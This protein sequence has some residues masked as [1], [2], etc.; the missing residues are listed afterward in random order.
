LTFINCRFEESIEFDFPQI[1]HLIFQKS[2]RMQS[3][4]NFNTAKINRL[5]INKTH[6]DKFDFDQPDLNRLSFTSSTFDTFSISRNKNQLRFNF[7][8]CT[9]AGGILFSE[10]NF[11][12]KN[13]LRG[14]SVNGN[15]KFKEC[16]NDSIIRILRSDLDR[17]KKTKIKGNFIFSVMKNGTFGTVLFSQTN[18]KKINFASVHQSHNNNS[19]QLI[20]IENTKCESLTIDSRLTNSLKIL[21]LNNSQFKED[22]ACASA[23]LRVVR[24]QDCHIKALLYL[25]DCMVSD[26]LVIKNNTIG[27]KFDFSVPEDLKAE[28]AKYN[29]TNFQFDENEFLSDVSFKGRKFTGRTSFDRAR[30]HHVPDFSNAE[31]YQDTLMETTEFL[32]VENED[33]DIGAPE[34]YRILKQK[35]EELRDRRTQGKLFACEQRSLRLLGRKHGLDRVV[36]S[37]YDHISGYGQSVEKPFLWIISLLV[38]FAY[39]DWLLLLISDHKALLSKDIWLTLGQSFAHSVKAVVAPF[40]SLRS[41]SLQWWRQALAVLEALVILPVIAI[42]FLSI[43]WQ[44]KRD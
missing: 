3:L 15:I 18:C 1:D 39:T 19:S 8:N 22:V 6:F 13:Y 16:H 29:A 7:D 25:R 33:V 40:Y 23:N 44:F 41:D 24:I 35:M 17:R 12:R 26:V 20:E 43:R 36:S 37:L 42:F 38:I 11:I 5:E 34:R 9:F 32:D 14:I 2:G 31:L 27:G 28:A 4:A 21:E 10:T 30:F